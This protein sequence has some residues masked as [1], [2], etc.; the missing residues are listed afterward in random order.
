[1]DD[2]GKQTAPSAALRGWVRRARAD[3]YMSLRELEA[4]A[5]RIDAELVE[6]PKSADGEYIHVGDV[7]YLD[8]GRKAEV[9]RIQLSERENSICFDV[10]GDFFSLWPENLTHTAPDSFERI[11]DE[12][13]AWCNRVDVDGDACGKPR[14][15][16]ER[17]R[18][19][20]KEQ[21]DE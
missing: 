11:A 9:R 3:C 7:V 20:A 1:M 5:D 15:L 13:D 8:D 21:G 12:L 19:L 18:K 4:I 17:I 2:K 10:C 16:A 6:L 14:V